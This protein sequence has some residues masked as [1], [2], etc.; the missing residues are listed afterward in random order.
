MYKKRLGQ[1]F[2][3]M[4]YKHF[5]AIGLLI[6]LSS[7]SNEL[8]LLSIKDPVPVVY[9]RMDPADSIFYLTLTRSFSGNDNGYVLAR[10]PDKVFYETTDIRLEGWA[11]QYK[12]WQTHFKPTDI[13]KAQ[14][15]FPEVSGYCYQSKNELL[16][17]DMYGLFP[18][19]YNQIDCFRLVLDLPGNY[20]PVLATVALFP[21]PKRIF[22]VTPMKV[23]DLYPDGSNYKAGIQFNPQFVKYCDLVCLFRYQEYQENQETW[24]DRS[25][26]F[27]LRRNIQI[28]DDKAVTI[29]DP[30][31][32]FT[33][34]A[35][36]IQPINDTIIRKFKS[37]D[38]I[39][40]TGDVNFEEYMNSYINAGNLDSPPVGNISHGYGLFTMVRSLKIENKMT[41]TYRT[42]DYLSSGEYT[43]QLGFV[44]W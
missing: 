29:I 25:V 28:L 40:L 10:D 27:L 6:L 17:L 34:I 18:C 1:Y 24:I 21:L 20:G 37:L 19:H 31:L 14:G 5:R 43:K 23:L 26:E 22:P 13:T 36:N 41:M 38:L 11:N 3:W 30:E 4:R 33:K 15:I 39:F 8:D 9:F 7:C 42:L 44:R 12:I 2:D 32:F 35:T 16:P